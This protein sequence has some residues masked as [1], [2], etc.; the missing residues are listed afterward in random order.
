VNR[1]DAQIRFAIV[2]CWVASVGLLAMIP[3]VLS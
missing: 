2:A 3:A 1:E